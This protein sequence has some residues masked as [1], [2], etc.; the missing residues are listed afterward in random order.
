MKLLIV[1]HA[2]V[3]ETSQAFRRED[4]PLSQEGERLFR[5]FVS[6]LKGLN[7]SFDLVLESPLLRA[8]QTADIL[9]G[10]FPVKKRETSLNLKPLAEVADL[11]LELEARSLVFTAVVGH[12][13]FVSKLLL[14]SLPADSVGLDF[15][16]GCMAL[17]SF[18]EG[19][20]PGAARLKAF[21]APDIVT[22]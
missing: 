18:P 15:A 21:L 19:F 20:Q 16:R 14:F 12:Q 1:R 17:L 13:P 3:E 9:C 6:G 4:P 22:P 2:P 8:R 11:F 7:W 5:D 10:A